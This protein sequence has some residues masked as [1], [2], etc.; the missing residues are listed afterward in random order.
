MTI[1]DD[2]RKVATEQ[3]RTIGPNTAALL[4]EGANEIDRL[5]REAKER[6]SEQAKEPNHANT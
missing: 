1:Q 2:M 6:D 5:E 3:L 4:K